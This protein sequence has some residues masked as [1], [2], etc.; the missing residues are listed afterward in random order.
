MTGPSVT[1]GTGRCGELD[2]GE[3]GR[4]DSNPHWTRF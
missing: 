1:V 3:W 4:W 2:D